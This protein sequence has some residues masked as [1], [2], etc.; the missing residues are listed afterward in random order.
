MVSHSF[1]ITNIC[2]QRGQR[3]K[4]QWCVV[5]ANRGLSQVESS[6]GGREKPTAE[7]QRDHVAAWPHLST[8]VKKTPK[9][10]KKARLKLHSIKLALS[11]MD[12]G[13]KRNRKMRF[14]LGK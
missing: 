2:R 5:N 8:Q 11:R 13:L 1:W 10:P 6:L 14:F 4:A 7:E 3:Q 9:E 12:T